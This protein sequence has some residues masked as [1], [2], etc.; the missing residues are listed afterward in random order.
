MRTRC[1]VFFSAAHNRN[2]A[3]C[4][5]NRR[6]GWKML[7][8]ALIP[9]HLVQPHLRTPPNHLRATTDFFSF[10]LWKTKAQGF[11]DPSPTPLLK[12]TYSKPSSAA[13]LHR[14]KSPQE[15]RALCSSWHP[16]AVPPLHRW[17]SNTYLLRCLYFFHTA[18]FL[19]A[20]LLPSFVFINH[21]ARGD[22][23]S[24]AMGLRWIKS[25][26]N[27][28]IFFSKPNKLLDLTCTMAKWAQKT[29]GCSGKVFCL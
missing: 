29:P 17:V 15:G 25:C 12:G 9:A 22:Q 13:P 11:R 8:P 4:S 19:P 27:W 24:E 18:C 5:R 28:S 6:G 14:I 1:F 20:R 3:G 7:G 23:V 2:L 26:L 21:E 16:L 10:H